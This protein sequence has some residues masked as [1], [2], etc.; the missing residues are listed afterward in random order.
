[1]T[2]FGLEGDVEAAAGGAGFKGELEESDRAEGVFAGDGQGRAAVDGVADVGVEEAVVAGFGGLGM[3][4]VFDGLGGFGGEGEG[5]PG[6]FGVGE[7]G[8]GRA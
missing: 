3:A 7:P 1:M 6:G 4:G 8:L 2:G 5:A